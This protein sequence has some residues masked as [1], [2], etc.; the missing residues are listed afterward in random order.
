M[1]NKGKTNIKLFGIM[2]LLAIVTIGFIASCDN[3][4]EDK[5][6][7]AKDQ[8]KTIGNMLDNNSSI[9]VKGYMTNAQWDGV[10]ERVANNL[11]TLFEQDKAEWGEEDAAFYR[12]I[13]ARGITYSVETNPVGYEEFKTI[14]DGKTVYIALDKID[15]TFVR[16]G[17][18]KLNN[19]ETY[20][21]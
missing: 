11:N 5:P 21:C 12:G 13:L 1:R 10:P 19:N 9:T 14:G 8:T 17:M 7:V 3:G 20:I 15:T 2:A 16:D 18:V 4:D 6:D